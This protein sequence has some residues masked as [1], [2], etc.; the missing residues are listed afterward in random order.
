MAKPNDYI[1]PVNLSVS[2]KIQESGKK[3]GGTSSFICP[4]D[5]IIVGRWH[6]GDENGDTQYKYAQLIA[7]PLLVSYNIDRVIVSDKIQESGKKTGGTS[8]FICPS[9]AV[10]VGR[11]HKS[12]ENGDTQYKYTNLFF[13]YEKLTIKNHQWSPWIQESGKGSGGTS[14]FMCPGHTILT[15]REHKGDENGE[16]R[17]R[18]SQVFFKDIQLQVIDTV[19]SDDLK[20]SSGNWSTAPTNKAMTG[21][22]HSGDE[23]GETKYYYSYLYFPLDDENILQTTDH[24]WSL[25]I[26]ESGK[27]SGGTS[28]FICPSNTVLTGREH[29]GDENGDT[30]YRYSMIR[31]NGIYCE[32]NSLSWSGNIK[33]S[34]GNWSTAPTNGVMTGRQHSGDENGMT[35]YQ[36]SG[37]PLITKFETTED[38]CNA[39]KRF[40]SLEVNQPPTYPVG[41]VPY[42]ADWKRYVLNGY[43]IFRYYSPSEIDG[44]G[45]LTG[46]KDG[47]LYGDNIKA[48]QCEEVVLYSKNKGHYSWVLST[49][50]DII[51]KWNSQLELDTKN[52]TRH[53]DLGSGEPVI[54]A[55][56]FY[57]TTKTSS[58]FIQELYVELNDSS[59][60]YKPDGKKCFRYVLN[61]F[62]DVGIKLE[63]VQV[64]ARK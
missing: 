22:Q 20:E 30:R 13:N 33:E 47:K 27:G 34:S 18:Y 37:V 51:Y 43:P 46:I 3:T 41:W 28:E 23:N 36:Y 6:K 25:W 57:L 64:Y 54:C 50:G 7:A 42:L 21:R 4:S 59:G 48:K 19:V 24:Q 15:G 63:N 62:E 31:Y 40:R 10:I 26:Q 55:G 39:A 12:D 45:I 1:I 9:D 35:K 8:S 38:F 16:T 32:I 5:T 49:E 56:E 17:Y 58:I 52:Y 14:E 44:V 61:K 29:K 53:S 11:W 2:N 60:H